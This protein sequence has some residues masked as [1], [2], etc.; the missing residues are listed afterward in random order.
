MQ[1]KEIMTCDLETIDCDST[2]RE[3]A[4]KMKLL[5]VGALPVWEGGNLVGVITDRDIAVRAVAEGK[6]TSRTSVGEIMTPEVFHCCEDDDV[7]EAARMME[8]KS[9]HR[10]LV[11]N[12][13]NKPVG[14]VSLADFA[15]KSRDE[16]LA[17]EV[18]EKISEPACPHR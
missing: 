6:A 16:H 9:I 3:A 1:V 8:D 2:L 13:D 14:F 18:L 17:W 12:R 5:E 10:L 15:V 7:H 4:R 11:L